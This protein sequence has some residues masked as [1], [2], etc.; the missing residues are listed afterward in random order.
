[1]GFV[2]AQKSQLLDGNDDVQSK[3]APPKG[4]RATAIKDLTYPYISAQHP[5]VAML[6]VYQ[7]VDF[8]EIA[9]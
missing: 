7:E 8:H 3:S 1:M 6:G 5:V 2:D 9:Y 4:M